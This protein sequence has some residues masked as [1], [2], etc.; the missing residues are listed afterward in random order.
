[1]NEQE[2]KRLRLRIIWMATL[3]FFTVMLLMGGCIYVFNEITQG[4]EVRQIIN[5]IIDN[6]GDLPAPSYASRE[7]ESEEADDEPETSA[8]NN[9]RME[10]DLA[11]F[12]GIGDVIGSTPDLA[13]TVRY[14]AVLLDPEGNAL[15]VKS[16]L[17]TDLEEEE[18]QRYARIALERLFRYGHFG[19]F[20]YGSRK[21]DDGSAVVVYVD[22]TSQVAIN[23]RLL[24]STLVLLFI[25]TL[26][27]FFVMRIFSKGLIR[28]EVE[29]VEKQK[30]FIT[31]ASHELKTP[32][33]VIR[34]N[35]EMQEMLEGETEWTTSTM[36]QVERL[37]GLIRNLVLIARSRE[38]ED[39]PA[40]M[41]DITPPVEET[42]DSFVPVATSEGKS[43][44][45]QLQPGVMLLTSDSSIR[46]I[47]SLLIDNA[48]KYCD[49]GGRILVRLSKNGKN[50]VLEVSNSYAA[51]KEQDYSRFFERF[52]REDE[53]H[54]GSRAGGYGIGLS[55]AE[56]LV[57][58]LRGKISVSWKDGEITF[59]CT[60]R[61][62]GK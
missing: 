55:I 31:N 47:A 29:N 57:R 28:A 30:R 17:M 8:G 61:S 1:M 22:R 26:I 7:E 40:G 51:G 34:A 37:D 53:S 39:A 9:D 35:T 43:L 41:I 32:L 38:K 42:A 19:R 14:F 36:R 62:A 11:S 52:Y 6:D 56:S 46:Q 60:F 45:K 16:S 24:Y 10:W 59:T 49:D 54:S 4:N 50:V 25:G 20:Y 13:H 15:Q 58:D 2:I 44:E 48:V 33:A 3:A 12:F 21:D 23:N 5:Y 27:S 18:A